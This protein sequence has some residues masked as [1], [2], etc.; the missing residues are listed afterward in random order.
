MLR[1]STSILVILI[2]FSFIPGPPGVVNAR[3][4]NLAGLS[5][6]P[7]GYTYDD[8][9][10]YNWIPASTNSGIL[11]DDILSGA[12]EIG[13]NFPF[14]EFNYSQL[15]FSTN[16]GI[17]FGDAP[18]YAQY[19]GFDIPNSSAPNNLI[20][21][22][23]EDLAV[24][25]PDSNYVMNS[26][27]VFY[28]QGGIAPN[29]YFILEWRDVTT[30]AG[31]S[32]FSFETI[33]HE[34][35]D[36]VVQ[37]QSLPVSYNVPPIP[38][39]STVGIENS[40]GD[41][42]LQY[43]SG[44]SGL[45]A[46]TAIR[47]YYPTTPTARL[48]ITPLSADR[49]SAVGGTTDFVATVTNTGSMGA[50]TYDLAAT[51]VW[52]VTYYA[53]DKAT[54]LTD[55]NGNG[56]IDTGPVPQGSAVTITAKVATPIG[57]AVGAANT[58]T[59]TVR[60]S[61]DIRKNKTTLLKSVVPAPFAQIYRDPADNVM[62]LELIQA[63][64]QVVKNAGVA[65]GGSNLAMAAAPN[66][67]F[68]YL[69]TTHRSE[70]SVYVTEIEYTL[71]DHDGNTMRAVSKLRDNSGVTINTDDSSPSVAV[72]PN[73][74]IGVLWRQYHFSQSS[75]DNQN[76][77]F[78][79][80]DPSGTL[81]T[82]PT[83]ITNNTAWG[84]WETPNVP[85]YDKPTIAATDDD[86]FIIGW[87]EAKF[88]GVEILSNVWYAVRNTVNV[89]VFSPV[90]LTTGDNM[91]LS[92][93]LNN[94]TGGKAIIT[95]STRMGIYEAPTYAVIH[96]SGSVTKPATLL[97]DSTT[98]RSSPDAV[99]LPNGKVAI[100][101]A[102]ETGVQY[103]ILNSSYILERGPTSATSP[104]SAL[105]S[106]LSVTTDPFSHVIMTW[107][108]RSW[109]LKNIFYALGDS[110]GSFITPPMLYKVSDGFIGTSPNGQ[111]NVPYAKFIYALSVVRA[112]TNP[113]SAVS[114]DFTVT[115]PEAVT[116]VDVNDFILTT[117]GGISGASISGVTG[118]GP[119][120]VT[121]NTGTGNGT[122]RLDVVDDDSIR[123]G[124]NNPLGGPGMGN[125]NYASGE[126]YTITKSPSFSDVPTLYW[127]GGFIERLY[128]AGITGG[129]GVNPLQYCPETTVTRSQMAVFLERGIH[130][131]S[132][133]PPVVGLSTGF[134]DVQPDYW[135]GAWIKQLAAEGITG[136]CGP[137]NYCPESPV[138]RA[139]MAVFLLRSKHGASYSPPAVGTSTGFTD[140]DP[141][142]WAGAW[143][144]QLV[145]EGITAGC[146]V[147]MYCPE[148]PVTRA[149]MAVFLVKT[150]N[151]P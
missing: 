23:W 27:A 78:A 140:V 121:V 4:F 97:T 32:A 117:T 74:T 5:S 104:S 147:G 28:A 20:A 90:A 151:L 18:S 40:A 98:Y 143:I 105:G 99:L 86:H 129:C 146:G 56:L 34:N 30:F 63:N 26:G 100:A 24:S 65:Y 94:L 95:W 35:G 142:Y 89:T 58:A 37:H 17:T 13:F 82:G 77:Y 64:A 150:F 145:A 9:V 36:I 45:N 62:S 111:G 79:T 107:R 11:G 71:L 7:F 118:T 76:I 130:G 144:K 14:Y 8:R 83:N 72:A 19:G 46:L 42:G 149:Q 125:G 53:A 113:T 16:G 132:Y 85:F 133:H 48:K 127:A 106:E 126:I 115:F 101:W 66:G 122:I 50:D 93:V 139:Q 120:T 59:V 67:N 15:Y 21:P 31:S 134:A 123:D 135:A 43:Q 88:D 68:I 108:D 39:N 3:S 22:F 61:L 112:G 84:T 10:P 131:S 60:S 2:L 102:T 136:G 51:S 70:G 49:F 6:D 110:A 109:L 128:R 103:T 119:Y 96:S 114:V 38:Y 138:T 44:A 57:A 47:F 124:S 33:L 29:R 1:K 116:G 92:P 54:L 81:L 25:S 141:A 52:S 148:A 75:Y 87:E 137:G 12:V 73:G 55:T 91:S 80:L 41:E 69:W